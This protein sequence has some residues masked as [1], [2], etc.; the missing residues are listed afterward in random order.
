M[1]DGVAQRYGVLPSEL[2]DKGNSLDITIATLA[3]EYVNRKTAEA[4]GESVV[5]TARK[6]TVE[7]MQAMI[8]RVRNK[9]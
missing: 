9:N 6:L 3:Q 2:L 1:L 8:D 4:N 7:E 5:K